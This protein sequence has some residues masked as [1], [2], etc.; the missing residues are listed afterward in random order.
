MPESPSQ[1]RRP[2]SQRAPSSSCAR[3]SSPAGR[4]SCAGWSAIGRSVQAGRR[5]P[6]RSSDYLAPFDAG[7]QMEAFFG[8]PAIAGKYYYSDDL[9]GFNFERRRMKFF[10][11]LEAI[12]ASARRAGCAVGLY[13]LGPDRRYPAGLLGAEPHAA[14]AAGR[15][16]R[17][18]GS[19]MPRMF[20]RHYDTFDNL[21]C[22]VAGTRRFTLFAPRVDRQALC[23]PDRQHHGRASRSAWRR[24]RR[25]TTQKFP[26]FR[27]I[28]DQALIAELEA[29]R[30]ALSAE[31]V[32]APGGG[33]RAIQRAGQLLVGCFQRR[34]GCALYQP[35][36]GA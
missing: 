34:T 31:A 16:R 18:S 3:W 15:R 11:A 25:R 5:S 13:R 30:C 20:P 26:L 23:R 21:A 14:A 36:A 19:D 32:V 22:V 17:A 7:A 9:K 8:E 10:P 24:R 33:D 35:A 28:R 12:V 6:R 4:W 29:G 27:E 2:G 1:N